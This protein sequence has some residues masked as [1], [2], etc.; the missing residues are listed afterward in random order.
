MLNNVRVSGSVT[1]FSFQQARHRNSIHPT[2]SYKF[3]LRGI[4]LRISERGFKAQFEN[5][6]TFTRKCL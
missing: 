6:M 3:R 1:N 4:P 2:A 5:L